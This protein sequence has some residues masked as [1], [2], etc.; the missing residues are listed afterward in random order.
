MLL[1]EAGHA[2]LPRRPVLRGTQPRRFACDRFGRISETFETCSRYAIA[3]PDSIDIVH[4]LII[5]RLWQQADPA[6]VAHDQVR[7]EIVGILFELKVGQRRGYLVQKPGRCTAPTV[8]LR[9]E[10]TITWM[11]VFGHTSNE[12][13]SLKRPRERAVAKALEGL[14]HVVP[15]GRQRDALTELGRR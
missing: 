6:V 15:T 8:G 9:V 10:N 2:A 3:R 14:A 12:Q 11:P 13:H 5:T 7:N 1:Q 4:V